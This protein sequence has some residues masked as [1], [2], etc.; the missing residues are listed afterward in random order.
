M[1]FYIDSMEKTHTHK[2]K[3]EGRIMG[4]EGVHIVETRMFCTVCL[5]S[6]CLL[7]CFH[8]WSL[9]LS[10][11][12]IQTIQILK[13]GKNWSKTMEKTKKKFHP[14]SPVQL[15]LRPSPWVQTFCFFCFF[16][17]FSRLLPPWPKNVPK[18][19]DKK[20][21][22]PMSP[23]QLL[24]RPSPWVETFCFFLF[25]CSRCFC[26]LGP[27]MHQNLWKKKKVSPHVTCPASPQTLSMG[28]NFFFLFF[29]VF[30][31]LLPPWPKNVPKPMEK[32]G[33][34]PCHLSSFPSDPLHGSKLFVFFLFSRGCCNCKQY[35]LLF[36]CVFCFPVPWVPGRNFHLH[37][38]SFHPSTFYIDVFI[39]LLILATEPSEKMYS[40][41]SSTLSPTS[42]GTP[43]DWCFIGMPRFWFLMF[44]GLARVLQTWNH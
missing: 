1:W 22:H 7:I 37:W 16:L 34:T 2:K 4:G 10:Q 43:L 12:L 11:T 36:F 17:V 9:D 44:R 35:Q 8:S 13:E 6:S 28:R 26:H 41:N 29:L 30:S 27:K 21:F 42:L 3:T 38:H 39:E 24:L 5:K 33:F 18:P 32:K 23:V 20:K 14:M 40:K 31:R 15:P 25:W 19:M